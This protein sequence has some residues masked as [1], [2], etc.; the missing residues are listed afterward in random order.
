M[1]IVK[2][3][4]KNINYKLASFISG[5]SKIKIAPI[6]LIV[7]IPSLLIGLT[8]YFIVVDQMTNEMISNHEKQV[9]SQIDFIDQE[10][11]AL[12]LSLNNTSHQSFF[13]RDYANID[14]NEDFYIAEQLRDVLLSKQNSSNLIERIHFFLDSDSPLVFN[15]NLR[16]VSEDLV[17]YYRNFIEIGDFYWGINTLNESNESHIADIVL[18]R[19]V[20]SFF[21]VY[22][23]SMSSFVVELNLNTISQMVDG[24]NPFDT[25]YS[26]LIDNENGIVLSSNNNT[27]PELTGILEKGDKN[28]LIDSQVIESID[29]ENYSVITGSMDRVNNSW[30]YISA[31]P[32]SIITEPVRNVSIVII[33]VSLIGILLSMI[34]ANFTLQFILKPLSNITENINGKAGNYYSSIEL[35][36]QNL[37]DLRNEKKGLEKDINITNKK[38][39]SSILYQLVEGRF[40]DYNDKLLEEY[41]EFSYFFKGQSYYY[42]DIQFKELNEKKQLEK[43]FE[44][45][46]PENNFWINYTPEH[47]GIVISF[48]NEKISLE[49][50]L[51]ILDK[52][53]SNRDSINYSV[54][55]SR[56]F[57]SLY[58]LNEIVE[59]IRVK[60]SSLEQK[61]DNVI[62]LPKDNKLKTNDDFNYP[63]NIENKIMENI[64]LGNYKIIN[65]LLE[66][67]KEYLDGKSGNIIQFSLV[68]LYGSIQRK[69]I[70]DGNNPFDIYEDNN[71]YKKLIYNINVQETI[72]FL[73][74]EI[75]TPYIISREEKELSEKEYIVNEAVNYIHS[76][77]MY[78]IYLEECADKLNINTYTLSKWFKQIIGTNFIDYLTTYRL[79]QS[80]KLLIN[81]NK[82]IREIAEDV[83]YKNS[84]F[85]RIFK[86]NQGL[87]P[88][89]YRKKHKSNEI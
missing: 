53:T 67:F 3:K 46:F 68:Q 48:D 52:T 19:N 12:E 29:R 7:S 71:F 64:G 45:Y 73:Y 37:Q 11:Q 84:Y 10:F 6:L 8:I 28:N 42:I 30:T 66:E 83:G 40:Q 5:L 9:Q 87:T 47:S 79:E 44:E 89:Q 4:I 50:I 80:K 55:V 15:P 25:G 75:I 69:I 14:F 43:L 88:G 38:L 72:K 62:V 54:I 35:T 2:N 31:V 63:F 51:H 13:T 74:E 85:N 21:N 27:N 76:S 56:P 77:Y 23:E 41:E 61:T 17:T 32:V 81:T 49:D 57:N 36:I 60:K 86:K 24:L 59:Q 1:N 16:R 70:K 65:D 33:I 26:Y 58:Y 82:K 39:I 18:V 34:L 78:D 22:D 20:P